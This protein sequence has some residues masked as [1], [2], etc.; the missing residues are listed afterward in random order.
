MFSLL[1][2]ETEK[3]FK[4]NLTIVFIPFFPT[5]NKSIYNK[6][7]GKRLRGGLDEEEATSYLPSRKTIKAD[8][9]E[10]SKSVTPAKH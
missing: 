1:L 9:T 8:S 6:L 7:S 4:M 5:L 3:K 10:L 2:G